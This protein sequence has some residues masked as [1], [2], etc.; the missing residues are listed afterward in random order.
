[1][2][3]GSVGNGSGNNVDLVTNGG[4][5]GAQESGE[6]CRRIPHNSEISS[7]ILDS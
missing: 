4:D 1:M 5:L 6:V 2:R 3:V 7:K